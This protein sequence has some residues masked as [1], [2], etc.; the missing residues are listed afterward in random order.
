MVDNRTGT[1][2]RK[3]NQQF[4]PG[5]TKSNLVLEPPI[6]FFFFFFFFFPGQS[7][8]KEI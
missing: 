4:L 3:Y 6:F 7:E 2:L 5:A 1:A 8:Q